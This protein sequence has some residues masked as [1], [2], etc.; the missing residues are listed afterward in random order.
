MQSSTRRAPLRIDR[1]NCGPRRA[2]FHGLEECVQTGLG[3]F[4]ED[5]EA[6]PVLV[7]YPSHQAERFGMA[8]DE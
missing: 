3:A 7:P 5:F 6:I 1:I 8:L 4:G 2:L